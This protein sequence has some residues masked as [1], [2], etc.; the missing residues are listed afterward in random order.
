LL[1]FKDHRIVLKA[2]NGKKERLFI[3]ARMK[4]IDTVEPCFGIGI[5]DIV[6]GVIGITEPLF[7]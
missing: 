1:V 6:F 3:L 2:G 4:G 5:V 7:P